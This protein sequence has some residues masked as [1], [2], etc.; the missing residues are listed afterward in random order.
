MNFHFIL[1]FI[2]Y[3]FMAKSGISFGIEMRFIP[4]LSNYI[5]YYLIFP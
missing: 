5:V 4:I 2:F 3:L 1:F